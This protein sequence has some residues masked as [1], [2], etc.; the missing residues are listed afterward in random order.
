MKVTTERKCRYCSTVV[1]GNNQMCEEHKKR[2][3][4][5]KQRNWRNRQAADH[6]QGPITKEEAWLNILRAMVW[7]CKREH[8]CSS[9]TLDGL[10]IYSLV[11]GTPDHRGLETLRKS[12]RYY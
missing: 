7:Y 5:D 6:H 12:S 3:R 4:A 2:G 8:P 11:P 10:C 9:C 1:T